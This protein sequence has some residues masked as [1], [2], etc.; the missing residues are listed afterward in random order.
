M[1]TQLVKNMIKKQPLLYKI[2]KIN[3]FLL[4]GY[5]PILLE[6]PL[7]SVPRYGYGKPPHFKLYEIINKNRV[8]Y[9]NTLK[10]FLRFK[11]FFWRIAVREPKIAQEP[12][13]MNNWMPGL[14]AVALYSF[15]C[16]NNP[17]RY[18]EIGSGNSTKFARKAILDHSL[19]TRITSID[20]HPITEINSICDSIIRC[21]LEDVDI[22]IF[23]EMEPK[24][25]LFID[26]SHR[27]FM[28]SDVAVTFLEI[29][30][31]LRAGVLVEFHDILLPYD[32]P[33]EWKEF[34][35]SEQYLLA[36]SLLAESNKFDIVLPN[37]F[38]SK[39]HELND[40]LAPVWDNPETCAVK[41]HGWSHG[42]SFWIQ[43][44]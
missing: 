5:H 10:K 26:G 22:H 20:P 29:L 25:I 11:K 27:C 17:K 8:D 13:W 31:Q 6:Y 38:I 9:I 2:G 7:K 30:P 15:L 42:W 3:Y 18:F 14:D 4:K 32:Y 37:F 16:L 34:Y 40:E 19:Q 35:F 39:D 33:P 24:D 23:D 44:K 36:V 43:T 1:L 28:N 12:Y 21:P 41:R